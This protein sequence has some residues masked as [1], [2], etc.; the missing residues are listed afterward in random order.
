MRTIIHDLEEKDLKKIKFEKNDIILSS[1]ECKK[2]CIGC[3]SCWIKHP[4]YC[5]LKDEFSKIADNLKESEEFIIISK[6][7]YGCY[8]AATKRVLERCIGYVLP[9]F[10]MREKEIHH[11]AR[12]KQQLKLNVYLYDATERDKPVVEKLVKANALNLNAQDYNITYLKDKKEL[13]KCI[14]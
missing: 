6:C 13:L 7:R 11:A 5:A 14:H 3:F 1:L 2:N 12:Y 4:K 9:Y 10:T 8:S